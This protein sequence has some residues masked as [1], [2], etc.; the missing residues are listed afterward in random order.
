MGDWG[1]KK[2][3]KGTIASGGSRVEQ[4]EKF[5]SYEKKYHGSTSNQTTPRLLFNEK[6]HSTSPLKF[7]FGISI[8]YISII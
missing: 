5:K 8:I 1:T 2:V 7:I 4:V 3:L 6:R